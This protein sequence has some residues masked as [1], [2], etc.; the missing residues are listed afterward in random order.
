[1]THLVIQS[2]KHRGRNIALRAGEDLLI[3]RDP[4]CRIRLASTDVSRRHCIVRLSEKGVIVKD[5]GSR[6]GTFVDGFMIEKVTLLRPG[7]ILQVGPL[8]FLLPGVKD[9]GDKPPQEDDD[10]SDDEI[11]AWLTAD[12][13]TTEPDLGDSTELSSTLTAPPPEPVV[14]SLDD[15][16]DAR[17]AAEI[18]QRHRRSSRGSE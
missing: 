12:S 15:H 11:T 7:S 9:A 18:I 1:M 8:R 16:P 10:A 4:E 6:N 5:L 2:G 17:R 14:K 3:G 13:E